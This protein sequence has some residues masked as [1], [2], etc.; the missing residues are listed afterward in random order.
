[1]A[2]RVLTWR[3]GFS[4]VG[5][6]PARTV[7]RTK[8][9]EVARRGPSADGGAAVGDAVIESVPLDLDYPPNPGTIGSRV[10]WAWSEELHDVD[11]R[12]E[13]GAGGLL[14]EPLGELLVDVVQL[15][16]VGAVGSEVTGASVLA[17]VERDDLAVEAFGLLLAMAEVGLGGGQVVVGLPALP[18]RTAAG[19]QGSNGLLV[20]V[21]PEG[22]LAAR[23]LQ[24]PEVGGAVRWGLAEDGA[25]SHALSDQIVGAPRRERN[26]GD[27]FQGEVLVAA[28]FEPS[29]EDVD[30]VVF[31]RGWPVGG[32]LEL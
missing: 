8:G 14:A 5:N 18:P 32:V 31:G 7:P 2:D 13:Y 19:L 3:D 15:G 20:F 27:A 26:S 4:G 9:V 24:R 29:G 12:V 30:R 28:L 23:L 25:H 17:C 22:D 1:V 16:G 21:D 6:R 11:R 10:V